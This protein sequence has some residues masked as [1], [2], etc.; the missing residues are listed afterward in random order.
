MALKANLFASKLW[1]CGFY[2]SRAMYELLRMLPSKLWQLW[3]PIYPG[4]DNYRPKQIHWVTFPSAVVQAHSTYNLVPASAL[5]E[6]SER[7][8]LGPAGHKKALRMELFL[9]QESDVH[10]RIFG[11]QAQ[12]CRTRV[13]QQTRVVPRS[14]LSLWWKL[15]LFNM[16]LGTS[17]DGPGQ[18][19]CLKSRTVW[20]T[21]LLRILNSSKFAITKTV[22]TFCA[23]WLVTCHFLGTSLKLGNSMEQPNRIK[24]PSLSVV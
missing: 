6:S 1:A 20:W 21:V 23:P 24:W 16:F 17:N 14:N 9:A 3:C 19:V 13:V 15:L 7:D 12:S 4:E 22:I 10:K 2:W 5:L 18:M 8:L 11:F